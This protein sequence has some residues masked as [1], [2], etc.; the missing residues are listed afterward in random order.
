MSE[1]KSQHFE[2]LQ[3]H[4]GQKVDPTTKSRGVPIYPT[5]SYVFDDSQNAADSF[6][7]K[8]PSYVYSR[9][10]NPTNEVFENRIAALEGGV[11]AVAVASGQAAQTVA[12]GA[13]ATVGQNIVST[14]HL[15]GGT[16]NLLKVQFK[17]IG[18][19]VRFVNSDDQ[20]EFEKAIDENTRAIYVES[21]GNPGYSIPDFE[22]LSALAHKHKIPLVVDN[23]FG[24]GGYVVRPF[25]F[26]A[27]II[28]HSATK[29]IGGHGTTLG[30]VVV[31]SGKFNWLETGDK[32]PNLTGPSGAYHGM[33]FTETFKEA[34]FAAYV[35]LEQLRDFGAALNPFAAFLLLQGTETLSLRLDRQQENAMKLAQFFSKHANV[36][37]VLYPGLE[38]HESHERAKKYLKHGYG[39]MLSLGVKDGKSA[40]V[41]DNLKL[42]SNLANVGD[43]KTLVIAPFY[44]THSQLTDEE[45]ATAEVSSELIRVSV[46]TEHIDDIIADFETAFKAVY[47]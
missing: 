15:Y 3:L 14:S 38:N 47:N 40:A 13:L 45:K 21:I 20:V 22:G 7:L 39:A 33:V 25:D 23:T 32:Y 11:A 5:T 8:V 42:A 27:D 1:Q 26:G 12:L 6:A 28:V 44:T 36:E 18:I 9:V 16:Y 4:A 37:W 2:T 31:D 41:V 10:A 29:W 46:G 34:A 30:G 19:D 17:R 35:R 24:A 43:S